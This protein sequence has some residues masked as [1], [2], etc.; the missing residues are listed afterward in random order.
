MSTH[1]SPLSACYPRAS[2]RCR[3]FGCFYL[4]LVETGNGATSPT[5][6]KASGRSSPSPPNR[7]TSPTHSSLFCT[8]LL[9]HH[10]NHVVVAVA[11]TTILRSRESGQENADARPSHPKHL[12]LSAARAPQ[13]ALHE[14]TTHTAARRSRGRCLRRRRLKINYC[15]SE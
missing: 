6:W 13:E 8:P 1:I 3:V 14:E 12:P 4:C 15:K 11:V 7:P 2:L 5:R 9:H 10:T